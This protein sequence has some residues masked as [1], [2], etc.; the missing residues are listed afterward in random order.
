MDPRWPTDLS[1]HRIDYCH[2]ILANSAVM[3]RRFEIL[4]DSS[5]RTSEYYENPL[6]KSSVLQHEERECVPICIK[7]SHSRSRSAITT[8][9]EA[10]HKG[11]RAYWKLPSESANGTFLCRSVRIPLAG[12]VGNLLTPATLS[13]KSKIQKSIRSEGFG[14]GRQP[15]C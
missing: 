10:L 6:N 3:M 13:K 11:P 4:H 2:S 8:T 1:G 9:L 15:P 12:V 7:A 14:G 5:E